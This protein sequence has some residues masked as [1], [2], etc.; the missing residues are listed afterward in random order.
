MLI[1][2]LLLLY[3]LT[4]VAAL[5]KTVQKAD[6]KADQ[7]TVP[8]TASSQETNSKPHIVVIL[9][10]DYGWGNFG[11]HT[12]NLT[13]DAA[14]HQKEVHT[15]NLDK[16]I[17][18]GIL[19]DRHYAY[20]ICSPS[21]S[22]FQSG[23]LAVHVN[24]QNV[25]PITFNLTDPVSGYAGVPR[26]MTGIA[27]KMKL[28]GYT[29]AM[30]GKWDAGMATP[31]HTPQGRGF[32]DWL[33]YYSHANNYWT[34]KVDFGST[35]EIDV[36]LGSFTDFSQT[37]STYRGGVLDDIA[38]SSTCN[39][40]TA[41]DPD[42]YEEHQFKINML[43]VIDGHDPSHP[44]F[45][46]HSFHLLHTPL[47]IPLAYLDKV[48]ALIAPLKFDDVGRRKY[49]AMTY[50]MDETIGVLLD[51]LVE[52]GMWNNTLVVFVTDNGGAIYK[53][54][55]A[56]NW[57]L[58]GG[59]YSDWEGGVR[60]NGAIGGGYV[61][62]NV[63]G[64]VYGGVVSIADWYGMFCEIVGVDRTDEVSALANQWLAKQGNLPMLSPVNTEVTGLWQALTSGKNEN[65]RPVLHLSA[66]A[67]LRYPYKLI[68]GKQVY[69][70]HQGEL[71]PNCS[72]G[73]VKPWFVDT[74]FLGA[75]LDTGNNPTINENILY[76]ECG[77]GMLF[78]V[79][80]D[81]TEMNNLASQPEHANT[82]QDM[83]M[84]LVELNTLSFNPLRGE[85]RSAIPCDQGFMN[86]GF[87][88]PFLYADGYYTGP[89][90][91]VPALRPN[92]TKF[93]M[94][95]LAKPLIAEPLIKTA[96][97]DFPAFEGTVQPTLDKCPP[98]FNATAS[99]SADSFG[100]FDA[101]TI[102]VGTPVIEFSLLLNC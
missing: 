60:T 92:V 14:Q 4:A 39:I 64:S 90:R 68:T 72:T 87:M 53:P 99:A 101:M 2:P 33:G 42:C 18:N 35:G 31:Q 88:G 1:K 30:T 73:S 28:A 62:E 84:L 80:D 24:T 67:V 56:N 15:P 100:S 85:M 11:A 13:S 10:D 95:Q 57:P 5:Q 47:E 34:K 78:N 17:S 29:T 86:G 97:K 19:L 93:L 36:C 71:Y 25:S 69:S 51:K 38:L 98:N 91:P 54:A 96:Q 52:K 83:Q 77:E 41:P 75:S 65:L 26:N 32:D 74:K 8:K 89:F 46:F 44:L 58:K 70:M 23:R 27:Q 40:S 21:R 49:A 16:L 61:P 3:T 43:R 55:S 48:D 12:N 22:S 45:Y 63:R 66:N 76:E 20:K 50:Y 79:D 59:K 102:L 6:Q 37:N 9:A 94:H 81:P 82:L 7:K